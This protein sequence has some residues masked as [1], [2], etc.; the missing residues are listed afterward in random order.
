MKNRNLN[1]E[2][3]CLGFLSLLISILFL[4]FG[5][6]FSGILSKIEK[7]ISLSGAICGAGLFLILYLLSDAYD[8]RGEQPWTHT[9]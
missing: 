7:I 6:T 5:L 4:W 1:K 3:M 9:Y 8:I 2:A